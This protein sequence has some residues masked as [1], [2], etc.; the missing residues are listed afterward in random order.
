MTSL[1]L[2]IFTFH[3]QFADGVTIKAPRDQGD[4]YMYFGGDAEIERPE[5]LKCNYD[6]IF[7]CTFLHSTHV[8]YPWITFAGQETICVQGG[9]RN[10]AYGNHNS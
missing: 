10:V 8:H 9:L 4:I 7:T 3:K 1:N 5:V 2:Y 6:Q